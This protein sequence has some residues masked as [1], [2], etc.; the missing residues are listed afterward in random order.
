MIP[1]STFKDQRVALFG[2]GGSGMVTAQALLAGEAVLTAFDDNPEKVSEASEMDIPV[3]DLREYDFANSEAL[4]LA[5]GVPLTHPKPHWSVE[6]AREHNV[7]VIGDIELFARERRVT[8][9][10]STFV[11]ITGTNGKSTTTAL[12]S[13]ILSSAGRK[14]EM[15]GNIG[16]AVLSLAPPADDAIHVVECSSYQIDLAPS[17]DPLIGLLLNLAP[18]H[19]ER[20]GSMENYA[21]I[22]T[23]LVSGSRFPIIGIDDELTAKIADEVE[24]AGKQVFRISLS[25]EV[26]DGVFASNNSLYHCSDGSKEAVAKLDGIASLRGSHNLENA[27]AA[28]MACHLSGLSNDEIQNGF[29]TFPGLAHRMEVIGNI[30]N[31]SFIND[32]KATNSD[33]AGMALGSFERIYWIAGGLAKDGGI[34]ELRPH[35]PHIAKAYLIG[36]AA[37]EFAATLGNEVAYEISGT[38]DAALARAAD[39]AAHDD[40]D[41]S[42]VLLSPA[43]ASFDQF[44]NFE[45]RGDAFRKAVTELDNLV[46]YGE[47]V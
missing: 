33:A 4:V 24:A 37:P 14:V 46:P 1:V 23:R 13:H 39:D 10:H 29:E 47:T 3:G 38:I 9:P 43:C 40:A 11:A 20:H 7:P 45:V 26:P 18:D 6:L 12:I 8:A 32:S 5:P 30:G 2:L 35:F 36:E 31:T 25:T 22:K 27:A 16:R 34:E 15:G 21:A 41:E 17:L 19:L 42:V 28:W 44:A